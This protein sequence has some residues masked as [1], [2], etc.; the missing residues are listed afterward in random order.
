M[1]DRREAAI[2]VTVLAVVL[3]TLTVMGWI[4]VG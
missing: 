2:V 1:S 4:G 3:V